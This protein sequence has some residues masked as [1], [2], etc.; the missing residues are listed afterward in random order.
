MHPNKPLKLLH[1][2]HGDKGY[3]P[4]EMVARLLPWQNNKRCASS[5]NFIYAVTLLAD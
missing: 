4:L 5:D 2:M 1:I 3:S